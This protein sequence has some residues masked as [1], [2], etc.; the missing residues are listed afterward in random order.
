MRRHIGRALFAAVTA[1]GAALLTV[2]LAGPAAAG[3]A[4]TTPHA[5][6]YPIVYSTSQAGYSVSGRWFR[7]AA[8]TVK[9]PPAG[10]VSSYAAVV[11]GGGGVAPVTLGLKAGG[12]PASVGWS[13]GVPPFGMGGGL[14][15]Q[16]NP[17]VGDMVLLDLYYNKA[18]GGVVATATDL[19][20]NRTQDIA[21]AEGTHALFTVAEVAGVLPHDPASPPPGNIRLWQFTASHVTTYT[22]VRGS[23]IGNWTTSEII[24]TT[25]GGPSGHVVMS[26]SFLF[27]NGGDFG[28]W[29]RTYLL[30]T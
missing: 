1:A 9:V 10:T 25:N 28:A 22:G 5:A 23:M 12:G 21:I 30:R 8:T 29:L 13:V 2:G 17:S 7:F 16:V 20:T 24:D 3:A 11:L 6:V 19:T 14:L 15:S 26:P 27:S 18:T 4:T